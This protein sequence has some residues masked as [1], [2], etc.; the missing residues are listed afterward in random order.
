MIVIIANIIGLMGTPFKLRSLTQGINPNIS[1]CIVNKKPNSI[2]KVPVI[3]TRC[4]KV[5]RRGL[6]YESLFILVPPSFCSTI[7]L[8]K[9]C[10]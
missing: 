7:N 3:E 9:S 8:D 1:N 10:I 2:K 4:S 6:K 5:F